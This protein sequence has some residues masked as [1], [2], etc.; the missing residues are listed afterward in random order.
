MK[1]HMNLSN[2]GEHDCLPKKSEFKKLF[3]KSEYKYCP[4]GLVEYEIFFSQNYK[5]IGK[6]LNSLH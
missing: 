1:K 3:F 4:L 6:E 5:T 2:I